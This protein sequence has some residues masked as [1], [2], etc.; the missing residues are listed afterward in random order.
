MSAVL[1][2]HHLRKKRWQEEAEG[3]EKEPPHR[4]KMK[5]DTAPTV[6]SDCAGPASK[7]S[8]T[9]DTSTEAPRRTVVHQ[10][11]DASTSVMYTVHETADEE[12]GKSA[13]GTSSL[14]SRSE[15]CT[16]TTSAPSMNN[17]PPCSRSRQPVSVASV[18]DRAP[19]RLSHQLC[20]GNRFCGVN[21]L[22]NKKIQTTIKPKVR[23][24]GIQ[25][26]FGEKKLLA[27]Q[28]TQTDW[29]F[30]PSFPV[31]DYSCSVQT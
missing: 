9:W 7:R 24:V 1:L 13:N 3:E 19:A 21:Q 6:P 2:L 10:L 15:S 29:T 8:R 23:T 22:H 12:G 5:I 18:T 28:E 20:G 25:V 11:F 30:Q 31:Q 4:Q 27:S 14:S 26:A 16:L 17:C